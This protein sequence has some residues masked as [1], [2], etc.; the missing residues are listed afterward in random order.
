M[1]GKRCVPLRTE[2]LAKGVLQHRHRVQRYR[3]HDVHISGMK[4]VPD[5]PVTPD[6]D[7]A[8]GFFN[9][10][11]QGFRNDL[12]YL[13]MGVRPAGLRI[14]SDRNNRG[15]YSHHQPQ[16]RRHVAVDCRFFREYIS[17][18]ESQPQ[19]MNIL[20]VKPEISPQQVGPPIP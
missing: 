19:M 17:L 15:F 12:Q 6:P 1:A 10:L 9:I 11:F 2:T 20:V 5:V 14:E 4:T 3:H 7:L 18:V 8:P 13:V 16:N